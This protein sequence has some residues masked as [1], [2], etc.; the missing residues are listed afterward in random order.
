[1]NFQ[2]DNNLDST[3]AAH[4]FLVCASYTQS[5][6]E[7]I[8]NTINEFV[9]NYGRRPHDV[10]NLY[11]YSIDAGSLD[12]DWSELQEEQQAFLLPN[13]TEI[14]ALID[15]D[16]EEHPGEYTYA[17]VRPGTPFHTLLV[18]EIQTGEIK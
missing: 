14:N 7:V 1:M 8:L 15:A 18:K 16:M 17:I 11:L 4:F 3:S 9:F 2:L 12:V 5:E 13:E 10:F 6:A